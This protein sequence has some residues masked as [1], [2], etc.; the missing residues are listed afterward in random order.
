MNRMTVA[1]TLAFACMALP[2]QKAKAKAKPKPRPAAAASSDAPAILGPGR[3]YTRDVPS[4]EG[5]WWALSKS[6][7][8]WEL[9]P[10]T[11]A[12]EPIA[13]EGDR[14]DKKSGVEITVKGD[15]A[16]LLLRN[17]PGAASF[18]PVPAA[19]DL[20]TTG[21]EFLDQ[22]ASGRLGDSIFS[23]WSEPAS[24]GRTKGYVV[25]LEV[26]GQ[27]QVLF[28]NPVCEGCGWELMWAGD[29]DGDGKLDLLLATTD[30]DNFG[31]LRLFLSTAAEAGQAMNQVAAQ[32]WVF[33]D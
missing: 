32:R 1:F 31:T 15:E 16:T 9:R 2:A 26:G 30:Q 21:D 14:K 28:V 17:V 10:A 19:S 5:D 29:L 8:G 6:G 25:K 33:G 7:K 4:L 12:V 3:Y 11:L 24:M 23:V 22:R 18:R 13:M 20:A 27:E